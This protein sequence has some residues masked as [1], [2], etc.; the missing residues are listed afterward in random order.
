MF[1]KL[2]A[3]LKGMPPSQTG[4]VPSVDGMIPSIN[5]PELIH[6]SGYELADEMTHMIEWL[7]QGPDF[8]SF[9]TKH[10]EQQLYSQAPNAQ[11][12]SIICLDTPI[13]ET[14]VQAATGRVTRFKIAFPFS[15]VIREE[16]GSVWKI[17]ADF[18]YHLRDMLSEAGRIE[19]D[20]DE[21][22]REPIV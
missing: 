6:V 22:A 7:R 21:L 3:L 18:V 20:F 14:G 13:S 2:K 19:V 11:L 4:Y 17:R 9:V 10:V 12:Q 15:L 8:R 5:E 16:H 1:R